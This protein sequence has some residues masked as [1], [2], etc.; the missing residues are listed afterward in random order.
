MLP[1]LLCSLGSH[2]ARLASVAL[3]GCFLGCTR[4]V[5]TEDLELVVLQVSSVWVVVPMCRI[6]GVLGAG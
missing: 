1:P 6:F 3:L 5:S 2:G 4:S